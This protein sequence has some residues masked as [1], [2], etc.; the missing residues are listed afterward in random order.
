ME[1]SQ[2]PVKSIEDDNKGDGQNGAPI[3]D[4]LWRIMMDV[5][6]AIYEVREEDGHDPSRLFHR[7]VNKRYVPDY[8]D[9]IKEPMALSIL[10]QKINKRE[11][12]RFSD[13]VR[14]CALIPHNAQTYNRPMSQA[15]EDALVI[16]TI[17]RFRSR[18]QQASQ[19]RDRY[20]PRGSAARSRR[21]PRARSSS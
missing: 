11:Y 15:Y 7:S 10:K 8:Y 20:C 16:K 3:P 6:L 5:V 19:A 9:V 18:V 12:R 2:E 4:D 1:P 21:D 13:F 14:D 17:G